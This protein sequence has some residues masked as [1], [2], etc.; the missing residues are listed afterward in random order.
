MRG[1]AS[2][3]A[4]PGTGTQYYTEAC[5][6]PEDHPRLSEE[7]DA[8]DSS[9]DYDKAHLAATQYRLGGR[10]WQCGGEYWDTERGD[11][12]ELEAV[13]R[14]SSWCHTRP[15]E[16]APIRLQFVY[17]SVLQHSEAQHSCSSLRCRAQLG[18]HETLEYDPHSLV[19]DPTERF[20]PRKNI[21]H[22]LP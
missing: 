2:P 20:L 8:A 4:E 9:L 1:Q 5:M 6:N 7:L 14:K 10:T 11:I 3:N 18:R 21:P 17:E 15:V 19:E 22:R 16:E 12:A 13:V